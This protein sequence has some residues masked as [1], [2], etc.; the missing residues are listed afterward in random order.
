MIKAIFFDIDGTLIPHGTTKF[1]P[2]TFKAL[3]QLRQQ[4]IKVFIATG[5]TLTTIDIATKQYAFDGIIALNGQYCLLNQQ[6]VR[7][8]TIDHQAL[9]QALPYIQEKNIAC[10]VAEKDYVYLNQPT[11]NYL[12]FNQGKI[13]DPLDSLK[14]IYDH[15]VYQ[16]MVFIK[17]AEEKAFFQHL[18]QCKSARWHP[19]FADVIPLNG[20]KCQGIDA[21]IQELGISL[22]QTMAFGDGGNDLSM[23]KHVGLGVAMA[24]ADDYVQ[25]CSDYVTTS[26]LEDGIYQALKHFKIIKED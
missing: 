15:D 26:D 6:V 24:N 18:K 13:V 3:K 2:S 25:A 16:L 7:K 23:L 9:I 12:H 8:Q 10:L 14:R 1:L 17:Q 19:A 22:E 5:R 4:G 11:T 20:G 21:I